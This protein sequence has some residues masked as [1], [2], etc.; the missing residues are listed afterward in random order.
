MFCA[1]GTVVST[2][3]ETTLESEPGHPAASFRG[4]SLPAGALPP[5]TTPALRQHK[6]HLVEQLGRSLHL[7]YA[8]CQSD[9]SAVG[10]ACCTIEPQLAAARTELDEHVA[11]RWRRRFLLSTGGQRSAATGKAQVGATSVETPTVGYCA[12]L[13]RSVAKHRYCPTCLFFSTVYTHAIG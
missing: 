7:Q 13:E 4:G 12:E 10:K 2:P 9:A 3:K 11:D 8:A 6:S 1:T 5:G